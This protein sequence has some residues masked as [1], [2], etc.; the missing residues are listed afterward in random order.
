MTLTALLHQKAWRPAIDQVVALVEAAPYRLPELL[1][2]L[3]HE[4]DQVVMRGAMA[5]ADL[6]RAHPD[7]LRP[8]HRELIALL[9]RD[10]IDATNRCLFRYF[11]ELP[12]TEIDPVIEGDLLDL[13]FAR[14]SDPQ[15]TVTIRIWGLQIV[16]NFCERYP[17]LRDELRGVIEEQLDTAPPGFKSRGR[18]ILRALN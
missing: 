8:Y 17:E 7:W 3:Q 14:G 6:G 9:R 13:A 5:L 18:K 12:L 4:S 1:T 15:R 2:A 10:P 16:A 11:S